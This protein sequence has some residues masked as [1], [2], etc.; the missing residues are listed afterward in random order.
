MER[1][2]ELVTRAMDRGEDPVRTVRE[3]LSKRDREILNDA[4]NQAEW[5][6]HRRFMLEMEMQ[7]EQ[8]CSA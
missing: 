8:A 6:R 1:M 2:I 7:E 5:Q 3:F 4:L